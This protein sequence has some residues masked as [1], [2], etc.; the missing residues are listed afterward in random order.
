M[1]K[2]YDDDDQATIMITIRMRITSEGER[3]GEGQ[4]QEHLPDRWTKY[5][6]SEFNIDHRKPRTTSTVRV[7][8]PRVGLGAGIRE[9]HNGLMCLY[10][11]YV[12]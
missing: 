10:C 12:S 11:V 9:V 8:R 7:V 6:D 3:E 2:D 1:H 4:G 5:Y